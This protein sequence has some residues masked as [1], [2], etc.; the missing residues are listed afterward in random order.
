MSLKPLTLNIRYHL[1]SDK[2]EVEGDVSREGCGELVETFLRGQIG[3]GKDE[4]EPNEQDIYNIGL[5]WYP[6]NDK[7]EVSSDTGN[8]GLRDGI[9]MHYLQSLVPH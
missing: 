7:I 1:D 9:L 8:K 6:E 2:F 5:R 4:S 3:A